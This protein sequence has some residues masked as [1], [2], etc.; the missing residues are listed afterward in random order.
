MPHDSH[1]LAKLDDGIKG[2]LSGQLAP[3]CQIGKIENDILIYYVDSPIW[4]YT[5]KMAKVNILSTLNALGE[6]Y[7]SDGGPHKEFGVLSHIS[8][9]QIRVRPSIARAE[10]HRK[11]RAP[12]PKFSEAVAKS[13]AE[14]ADTFQDQELA[15]L[16]RKFGETHSIKP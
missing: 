6:Q 15:D 11:P 2:L 7:K 1:L 14:T 13:I 16:W 8:D 5:F 10:R 9:I 3:H 4:A 12:L